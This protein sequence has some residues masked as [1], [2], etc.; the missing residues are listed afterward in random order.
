MRRA[1]ARIIAAMRAKGAS[2]RRVWNTR[3]ILANRSRLGYSLLAFPC[4]MRT[5]GPA[6]RQAHRGRIT[7]CLA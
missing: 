5:G 4:G 6:S 1:A 7:L 3:L 2:P